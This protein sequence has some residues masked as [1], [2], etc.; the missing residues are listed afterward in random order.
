MRKFKNV[1][2]TDDASI[3][4]LIDK[5]GINGNKKISEALDN[6]D[7]KYNISQGD[8]NNYSAYK[9]KDYDKLEKT[10]CLII[11]ENM[12]KSVILSKFLNEDF[13]AGMSKEAVDKKA[14]EILRSNIIGR[15]YWFEKLYK[16]KALINIGIIWEIFSPML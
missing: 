16:K 10:N 3:N 11:T 15:A 14:N 4:N 6:L 9:L 12:H 8:F 5:M 13:I 2:F 7:R 1:K